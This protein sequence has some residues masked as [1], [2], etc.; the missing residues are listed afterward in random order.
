M[1]AVM[2]KADV[3]DDLETEMARI[4]DKEAVIFV[5]FGT[6][7]NL[8]SVM[9]H[10]EIRGS[11][12]IL[13]D[14]SH[15][16]LLEN[17]GISTIGCAHSIT[18]PSNLDRTM[19]INFIEPAIR[20]PAEAMC[21]PTTR[22]IFLM[23]CFK[24]MEL[25]ITTSTLFWLW[26]DGILVFQSHSLPFPCLPIMKIVLSFLLISGPISKGCGLYSAEALNNQS[27]AHLQIIS[28]IVDSIMEIFVRAIYFYF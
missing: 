16:H 17:G 4:L 15:I 18:V 12:V 26:V 14:Q 22:L 21:Y 28:R 25:G 9:V 13:G 19:D 7:S 11:E 10:C 1:I 8:I 2:A 20:D 23:R 27:K 5:P 24:I 6:M 3:D